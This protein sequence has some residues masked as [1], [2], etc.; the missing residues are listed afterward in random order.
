MY[1]E[2]LCSVFHALILSAV[3]CKSL[4]SENG[5]NIEHHS[6]LFKVDAVLFSPLGGPESIIPSKGQH[7]MFSLFA[8]RKSGLHYCQSLVVPAG[9]LTQLSS[10]LAMHCQICVQIADLA[11]VSL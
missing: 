11:N 5:S 8:D 4:L 1:L 9:F 10:Y 2:F 7:D 6:C 3:A